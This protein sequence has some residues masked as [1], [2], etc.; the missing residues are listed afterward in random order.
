MITF[1]ALAVITDL[2]GVLAD[3]NL[4]VENAWRVW[5]NERRIDTRRVL[6]V[7]HGRRTVDVLRIVAPELDSQAEA[8]RLIELEE[9]GADDVMPVIG[10]A[11]FVRTIPAGRWAVATSGEEHLART[12]LRKVGITPPSVLITAESVTHGKPDPE[13]YLLAAQALGIAPRDCIV[14]EDAP[15]G[16]D[17]A[18]AAGMRPIALLTTYPPSEL[19]VAAAV[20]PNFHSIR[21]QC[22]ADGTSLRIDVTET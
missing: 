16:L 6:A 12:R 14:F 8:A 10:A 9:A 20:V 17:A 22:N 5:S 7:A 21:L 18:R 11:E 2:D 3:S 19:T 13:V 1:A 15:A 4:V